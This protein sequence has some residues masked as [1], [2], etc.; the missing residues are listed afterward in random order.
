MAW[1]GH[2]PCFDGQAWEWDGVRFEMLHPA[3]ADYARTVRKSNDMSC[4]LKVTTGGKSVLLTGDIET[5]S[6]QALSKRHGA[7]LRAEVL[8]APHHGSRTSSSPEFIG[9][10]GAGA[11]IFPVGY[12]SRFRHP[13]AEVLQRHEATGAELLRTD[14]DGAVTLDLGGVS[15]RLTLEREARRRY[16]HGQ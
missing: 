5:V 8:L 13:N 14:R 16:W 12:R 7:R 1:A 15:R 9:A 3:P 11:V 6:E 4:V 10:V 2:R